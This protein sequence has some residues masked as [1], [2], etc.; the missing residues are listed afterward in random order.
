MQ[1]LAQHVPQAGEAL[2]RPELEHFIQQEGG[3]RIVAG[4]RPADQSQGAIERG[5]GGRR[6][7]LRRGG[8][9]AVQRKRRRGGHRLL[10]SLG[11][12]RGA[13]D[14]DVLALLPAHAVL[15]HVQQGRPARAAAA[16]HDR[17]AWG[18]GVKRGEDAAFKSGVG[19]HH[20]LVSCM[21]MRTP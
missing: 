5:A 8:E 17:N 12:A 18:R 3:G 11:R 14:I 20:R 10:E 13:L 7:L 15:Q 2:E 6:R 19:S 1:H 4:P 9:R 21:G 16:D